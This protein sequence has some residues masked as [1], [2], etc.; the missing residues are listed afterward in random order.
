MDGFSIIETPGA[1]RNIYI[2]CPQCG[3][4][5]ITDF[6]QTFFRFP[7][8]PNDLL[9]SDEKKKI[10]AYVMK[11]YRGRKDKPVLIDMNTVKY[12]IGKKSA[13]YL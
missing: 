11:K 5:V 4:Y 6:V 12:I 9:D 2:D 1:S 13:G 10:S 7:D 8:G 3:E